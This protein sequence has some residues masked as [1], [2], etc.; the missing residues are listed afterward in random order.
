MQTS[1]GRGR[2]EYNNTS[3]LEYRPTMEKLKVQ[4]QTTVIKENMAIKR[5][6]WIF[7][8]AVHIIVMFI[9]YCTL[10]SMK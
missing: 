9:L 10:L 2:K 7:D 6:K 1:E 4:F 5:V 8:F 3:G